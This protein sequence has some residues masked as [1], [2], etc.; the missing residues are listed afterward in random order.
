MTF[1]ANK[2]QRVE[3]HK[4]C[5]EWITQKHWNE[6]VIE[7]GVDPGIVALNVRSIE[8]IAIDPC[9]HEI[10]TPIHDLLNWKFT[11]FGHQAKSKLRGW[12]VSGVEG[13]VRFKPD[14]D[15]PSVDKEGKTAKYLS[16]KGAPSRLILLRV[17]RPIWEKIS[18]RYNVPIPSQDTEFW[19]WVLNYPSIPITLIE[20]EK[21]AGSLLTQGIVAIALPGI[22]GG[23]RTKDENGLSCLP[24][25]I[26]DLEMFATRDRE[27]NICF[28][29][30]TKPK[31]LWA[32]RRETEKLCRLAQLA[33]CIP[34][35]I[36]LPGPEKGADDFIVAHGA[37]ALHA[38][39][40]TALP[41]EVWQI[42]RYT[43]L[44]RAACLE[45]NQRYLE[46]LEL[47]DSAK[48]VCIKSPKGSGKTESFVDIVSE[49]VQTGQRVLLLT[50][51]VQLGQAI[52]DRV[53]LPFVNEIRSSDT[54]DLL[55]YGLCVDSLHANSQA[56]F[57]ADF[58]H[59]AIVIIDECEQVIWHLLSAETKVT[60]H[61]IAIL[62]Q[63][64]Q[65]LINT[66]TSD[67]GKVILSDADLSDLSIEFV[68][69]L[70][71]VYV[72]PYLVVNHW[73]PVDQAWEVYHY[74][75][76]TPIEWYNA[77]VSAIEEGGH[78]FICTHS[79]KAK[80]Q[81]STRTM[82]S[83]LLLRFPGKKIL[84]IDSQS[85]AD[86]THPA[87]G[88]ISHLNQIVQGYDIVIASPSIE[89]GVSI[90]VRGYFSA[91]WGCFQGCA[92]ENT[93]R[94]S[95]ARVREPVERHIWIAK[96]GLNKIGNGATSPQSLLSSQKKMVQATLRLVDC[97]FDLET[98]EI[99]SHHAA[100][101]IWA[102]MA[103][104]INIGMLKYRNLVLHGLRMEGH[105]IFDFDWTVDRTGLKDE[106]TEVR[107]REYLKER[108][109]IVA[110]EDITSSQ[111]EKLKS[112]K[113]KK[114]DEWHKERK[115]KL[116][117]R[118]SLK[119]T[120]ELIEKDDKGWHPQ[121]RLYYYLMIGR[122]FLKDRDR[123]IAEVAIQSNEI[124]LPTFNHA[125]LGVQIGVL[126]YLGIPRLLDTEREFRCTDA[127]L[128]ELANKAKHHSRDLKTILNLTIS[129]KDTPIAIAQKLLGKIGERLTYKCREGGRH[130]QRTRVYVYQHA[131]DG[132]DEVFVK[133]L[134]RDRLKQSQ[135][136]S[137]PGIDQQNSKWTQGDAA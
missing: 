131:Q 39:Y 67:S 46:K 7:S 65:L 84:R 10:T 63:L 59:N 40:E 66:L 48:F 126:D 45:V 31:T 9:T 112:Q 92:A 36:S 96:H 124:W 80:S 104:R 129:P 97:D 79:Q 110:A 38:C 100:L 26:P 19:E 83:H 72:D 73:K 132:R 12:R 37:E 81:W 121:I 130:Q 125:Q 5:P 119:V 2:L 128:V 24:Y 41:Y 70:S 61:R 103:V 69:K 91:V 107:D 74:S 68:Q 113:N 23:V 55:G 137:T 109:A 30:E 94:Q 106:V 111:Y 135:S 11:R 3:L 25:L 93:V 47:P 134:E 14:A 117:Q 116:Q 98:G 60:K 57:D 99:I 90:D 75:Q 71:E 4:A 85:I 17:P 136:V 32:V 87:Y 51:R 120:S 8:D 50:H 133:W 95:L 54:G 114:T 44:S 13:W 42:G 101:N 29:Y 108:E 49:A 6:W 88:C 34:K 118:Y 18:Q 53:G 102:Q 56:R 89:T 122:G 16:P 64:R 123:A 33:G 62:R 22:T 43:K 82:E 76:S 15:T 1:F 78:H 21:K 77:L 20:G 35:V 105:Q 58:W 28:D 115:H 52:C 27:W 86:P 127:D